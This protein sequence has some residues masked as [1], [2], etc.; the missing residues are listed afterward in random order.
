M[1]LSY[2]STPSTPL[3]LTARVAPSWGGQATSGAEALWSQEMMAG[4][5]HGR[6][7][8]RT[9]FDADVGYELPGGT[10][11]GALARATMRW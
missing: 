10:D 3:G 2:T 6:G 1:S 11:H 8:D 9:R 4:L 5:A 7:A